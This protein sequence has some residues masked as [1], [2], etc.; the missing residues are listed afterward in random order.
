MDRIWLDEFMLECISLENV[1]LFIPNISSNCSWYI[2]TCDGGSITLPSLY[3][4]SLF[5]FSDLYWVFLVRNQDIL[6]DIK[7]D[8]VSGLTIFYPT[9][10]RLFKLLG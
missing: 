1:C 10:D 5:G 9:K 8:F 7:N 6:E 2:L 3:T 4:S